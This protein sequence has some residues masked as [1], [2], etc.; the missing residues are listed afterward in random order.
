MSN[1]VY[2][3]YVQRYASLLQKLTTTFIVIIIFYVFDKGL[4]R[5]ASFVKIC[6]NII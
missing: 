6:Y 5:V 2:P 4:L 3:V 1:A